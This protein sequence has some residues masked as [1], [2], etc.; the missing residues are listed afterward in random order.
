MLDVVIRVIA[1]DGD[2]QE[3]KIGDLFATMVAQ[4]HH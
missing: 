3:A 2:A 1:H 4:N